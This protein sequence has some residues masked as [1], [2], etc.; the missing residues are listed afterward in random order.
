MD[1]FPPSIKCQY[2]FFIFLVGD[3]YPA[4][5]NGEGEYG[6]VVVAGHFFSWK[7]QLLRNNLL[8]KISFISDAGMVMLF[9]TPNADSAKEIIR[10]APSIGITWY[11]ADTLEHIPGDNC[12]VK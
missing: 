4:H 7:R 10:S 5:N 8:E 9:F 3:V 1:L 6:C 12:L 2:V 11:D